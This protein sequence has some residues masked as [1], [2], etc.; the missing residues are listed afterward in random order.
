MYLIQWITLLTIHMPIIFIDMWI[1][2][3]GYFC[4]DIF[5]AQLLIKICTLANLNI[6]HYACILQITPLL[7]RAVNIQ[8]KILC[9]QL[10]F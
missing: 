7:T 6:T 5:L 3:N 8:L 9:C 1:V 10:L 4:K 2:N